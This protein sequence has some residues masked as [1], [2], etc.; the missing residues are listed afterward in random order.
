MGV[1]VL[2]YVRPDAVRLGDAHVFELCIRRRS[3][4]EASVDWVVVPGV[5]GS[6][7]FSHPT[8]AIWGR[9]VCRPHPLIAAHP[10]GNMPRRA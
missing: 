9:H 1:D 4:S 6:S 5:E 8:K 2:G 7:P 3:G 10:G